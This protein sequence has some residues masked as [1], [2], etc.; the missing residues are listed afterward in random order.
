MVEL[1]DT[2]DSKSMSNHLLVQIQLEVT[3][4]IKI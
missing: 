3:K 1:A 2:V 4:N